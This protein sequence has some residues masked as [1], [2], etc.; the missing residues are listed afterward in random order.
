MT[1]TLLSFYASLVVITMTLLS[2][3]TS[4]VEENLYRFLI[5]YLDHWKIVAMTT[6]SNKYIKRYICLEIK[7][8]ELREGLL[9]FI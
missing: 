3:C 2:V 6:Y 5:K 4:L 8:V 1:M 9:S 7:K